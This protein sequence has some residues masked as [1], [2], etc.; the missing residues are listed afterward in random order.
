MRRVALCVV[1]SLLTFT[2]VVEAQTPAFTL[3]SNSLDFNTNAGT[4]AGSQT[5]TLTNNT[6]TSL[7]FTLIASTQS[8]GNWLS[9]GA[10]PNPVPG[11]GSSTITVS[12]SSSKLAPGTYTGSVK[13]TAG[14]TTATISVTLTINGLSISV[15]PNSISLPSLQKGNQQSTAVHIDGSANVQIAAATN[16]GAGWLS[17]DSGSVS[18]P[19]NFN[20]IVNAGSLNSGT[21]SGAVTLQCVNGSPCVPV[22]IPVNVTVAA[23][24]LGITTTS[25]PQANVGSSYSATLAASGG[26][27]PYTWSATGLPPGLNISTAGVVSGTPTVIGTFQPTVTVRD[28]AGTS[29]SKTLSLSVF[30]VASLV[31]SPNAMNLTAQAGQKSQTQSV[32]IQ[33]N[34]NTAHVKIDASYDKGSG[35]LRVNP[36]SG[37]DYDVIA[38]ASSLSM[39]TYTGTLTVSCTDQTCNPSAVPVKV[40]F[41]VSAASQSKLVAKPATLT[42]QAYQGRA[43]AAPQEISLTTDDGAQAGFSVNSTSPAVQVSPLS[44]TASSNPINLK[45]TP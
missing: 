22:A 26:V 45:V 41:L 18:S 2:A 15:S 42:F 4:S 7:A 34:S 28:S 30:G 16:Q 17:V 23:A 29:A 37:L 9:A 21:Y 14:T 38:D 20:V 39:G 19:G 3:S 25:L 8:G 5:V 12:I 31:V 1:V 13:V 44:G 24:S 33:V 40:T 43:N 11:R 32:H 27:P 6:A 10:T 36:S 35:W